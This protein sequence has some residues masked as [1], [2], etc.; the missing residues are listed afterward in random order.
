MNN[1]EMIAQIIQ[2]K[3]I[4]RHLSIEHWVKYELFTWQWY[5]GVACLVIPLLLWWKLV[6]KRRIF[7]ISTFGLLVIILATFLDVTGSELVLWNYPIRILPQI[8]LLFPVDFI[9]VPITY[10]LIYQHYSA[11]K[12]FLLAST[13]VALALAFVAEP[14]AVYIKQ[15]QLISWHYVYSFPIYITLAILSKNITNRMLSLQEG[16]L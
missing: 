14:L 8:P 12:Q 11:W 5:I 4:Y 10:M 15:Y 2:S 13:I 9:I 16:T 6:D 1:S 3:I 7:E